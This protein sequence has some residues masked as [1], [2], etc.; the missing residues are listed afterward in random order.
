[1]TLM[2]DFFF[3]FSAFASSV[4]SVVRKYAC[5]IKKSLF[6]FSLL[7]KEMQR[8]GERGKVLVAFI[9]K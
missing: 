3:S 8:S 2:P 6:F 9:S 5:M 4:S 1:M 7:P